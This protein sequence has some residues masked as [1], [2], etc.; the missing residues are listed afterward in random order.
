[1][2]GE[3]A[4]PPSNG[5]DEI[6]YSDTTTQEEGVQE[7]DVVKND[8]TY[9]YV[10]TAGRLR[11][12]QALPGEQMQEVAAHDLGGWGQELYRLPADADV[13][14]RIVAVTQKDNWYGFAEGEIGIAQ[15]DVD[16]APAWF[17][18]PETVVTVLDVSD[19][20]NPV[21]VSTT[22]FDG[23]LGSSRMIEDRLYLTLFHYPD[24]YGGFRFDAPQEIELAS[25]IPDY[26]V[27]M[28][29]GTTAAGDLLGWDS[30]YRPTDPDGLGLVSLVTMD[31]TN[32]AGLTALGVMAYP[33][34]LY[35]SVEAI[36]LTDTGYN[37]ATGDWRETTDIYKFAISA[38]DVSL[39]A[40]GSVPG[41]VLNQY[42]MS[43]YAGHL[44][45]ATTTGPS[46]AFD[47]QRP[48]VNAV[49]VLAQQGGA[50]TV[51]GSVENLAP[52]EEI[53]SARFLGTRG[54]LVTFEQIDPLF[55]F[56]LSNPAN[57]V[58]VGEWHGPGFS[59]FITP[60]DDNHLLTIGQ[61]MEME[62]EWVRP[63]GVQLSVF[64]VTDFGSPQLKHQRIIGSYST[65]SE[66]L[67]NPKAFTYFPARD[68]MAVPITDWGWDWGVEDTDG[69]APDPGRDEEGAVPGDEGGGTAVASQAEPTMEGG[70]DG[71]YVYR[72]TED[73]G[74]EYL[75]R[76][77]TRTEEAADT[78]FYSAFTRGVF[79]AE[80]VYIVNER[81]VVGAPTS[82][83]ET[84][85]W[86]VLFPIEDPFPDGI[87]IDDVPP[88][89]DV[90]EEPPEPDAPA[91]PGDDGDPVENL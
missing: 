7:A 25:L 33:G 28:A 54:F 49:Y 88:P 16:L 69:G 18:T 40:A 11:I 63:N 32:P 29:D 2:D 74:F 46:W 84:S 75:G 45:I 50:L 58:K 71:V 3:A 13:A 85:P 82:A 80:N 44:R 60:M 22:T 34:N 79:L 61:S 51:I 53:K 52:G 36:Y 4:A 35:A 10:L 23:S 81:G 77:T 15:V 17:T 64:D 83:V 14:T 87:G 8:S 90:E 41:R 1:V 19:H 76:L 31:V 91:P 39:A 30:I 55:T 59:A 66:C 43:E 38:T 73:N 78:W 37:H 12:V 56:D 62:G 67:F 26:D 48:S 5:T 20:A 6:D 65:W 68:L 24:Y 21:V 42:S 57:P 72:A 89:T 27:E 86:R 9:L 70:F 47:D